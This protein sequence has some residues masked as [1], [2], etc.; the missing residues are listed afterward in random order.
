MEN[1]QI[2]RLN[3]TFIV[4]L[5]PIQ[6]LKKCFICYQDPKV[7]LLTIIVL[8]M[9]QK[10]FRVILSCSLAV[11]PN[12][13]CSYTVHNR[14]ISLKT[15]YKKILSFF[16]VLDA[17]FKHTQFDS[18]YES[19]VELEGIMKCHYTNETR[20]KVNQNWTFKNYEIWHKY[21]IDLALK[22]LTEKWQI[23]S[24]IIIPY[25]VTHIFDTFT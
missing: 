14:W 24:V 9:T 8:N 18:E 16:Q 15:S 4:A 13:E 11:T 6:Y 1:K 7:E 19:A 12:S 2:W 22:L 3:L 21:E 23:F 17:W 5:R 25:F 20:E 10:L